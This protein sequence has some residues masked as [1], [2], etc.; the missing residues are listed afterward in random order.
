[1][2]MLTGLLAGLLC[3]AGAAWGGDYTVSPNGTVSDNVT[4][5]MWQQED[6][7]VGRTWEQALAYCENLTLDTHADWRLPNFKELESITDDSRVNPA[8]DPVAFPNANSFYYWSSTT[9]APHNIDNAWFV[10]FSTG[11]LYYVDKGNS[12][13][14]RCVRG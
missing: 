8:I 2:K 1:M 13:Y 14:A 10:N 4:G 12:Y 11:D 7:N 5:L 6:D 3:F 9:Y